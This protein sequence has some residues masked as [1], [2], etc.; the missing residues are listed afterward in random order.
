VNPLN[1]NSQEIEF[2]F[3]PYW[4]AQSGCIEV[5]GGYDIKGRYLWGFTPACV[6]AQNLGNGQSQFYNLNLKSYILMRFGDYFRGN[7]TNIDPVIDHW[8]V[9]WGLTTETVKDG[10]NKQTSAVQHTALDVLF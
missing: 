4:Y 2:L 5:S 9:T 10:T 8:A 1:N 3:I 7:N 6:G